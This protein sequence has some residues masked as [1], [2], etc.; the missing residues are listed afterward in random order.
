MNQQR[1]IW[2]QQRECLDK[3]GT[4]DYGIEYEKGKESILIDYFDS[5]WSG[6]ETDMKAHLDRLF[7][8]EVGFSLRP[9]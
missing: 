8:L 3:Q 4:L 5:D 2:E 1:S 9:P 7:H 6:D